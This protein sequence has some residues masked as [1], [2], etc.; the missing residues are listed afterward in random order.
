MIALTVYY[1]SKA[2]SEM[3]ASKCELYIKTRRPQDDRREEHC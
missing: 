1:L 3:T 2:S